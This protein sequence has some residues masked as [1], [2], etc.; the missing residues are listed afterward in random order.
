M[1]E[2]ERTLVK[3][4]L[5]PA[6]RASCLSLCRELAVSATIM[7]G[8]LNKPVFIKL[9]SHCG[10]ASFSALTLPGEKVGVLEALL[11]KTPMLFTLSSLRISFVAS[12]PF[13]TGN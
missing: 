11:E 5:H 3:K 10:F 7:T 13:I 12:N 1:Q 2:A 6:A 4:S 8:L 9:S